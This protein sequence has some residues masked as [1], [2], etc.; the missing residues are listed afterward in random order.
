[1]QGVLNAERHSV[2]ESESV[3]LRGSCRVLILCNLP[4]AGVDFSAGVPAFPA[5]SL[6]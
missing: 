6:L 2:K 3:S 1:M 4:G 5:E